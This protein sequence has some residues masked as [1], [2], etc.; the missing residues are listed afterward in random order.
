VPPAFPAL[1]GSAL[2]TGPIE[3]HIDIIMNGKP[4]T[5]M[6]AFAGQLNDA[7]IAGVITYKRNSWGNNVGDIVQPA[8]IKAL[9]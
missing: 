1:A 7:E 5:A 2:V 9:R 8:A 6:Q 3:G 4:G